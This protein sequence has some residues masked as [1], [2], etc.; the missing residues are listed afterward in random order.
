M[1]SA[2]PLMK[3]KT[4]L[5]LAGATSLLAG[6]CA[7]NSAK[8]GQPQSLESQFQRADVNNDEKVSKEEFQVLAVENAFALFDDNSDGVLTKAEFVNSGGSAAEF[9]ELDVTGSETITLAEAMASKVKMSRMLA[10]FYEAD[11]DEDGYVTLGEALA[12]RERVREI[13]R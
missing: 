7:T 13:V 8:Y 5:L 4:L 11:T 10:A 6:C 2:F 9:D 1:N 3:T 12:R